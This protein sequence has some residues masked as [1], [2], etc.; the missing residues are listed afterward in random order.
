[1]IAINYEEYEA[2]CREVWEHNRRY[3]VEHQPSISDEQYD[4][5]MHR[6]EHIEA[7][8]PEWVG[9][10]SPTQRVGEAPTEGFK[11]FVHKVPM[12]SL[13]N[14]YTTNELEDFVN[15]IYKLIEKDSAEFT[16][17]IKMDGLAI[18][19]IY[20]DGIL[21]RGVT[22]GD[23]KQGDDVTTNIRTIRSIPLKLYGSKVPKYLEVRGEVFLP[24]QTFEKL[25]AERKKRDEVLWANPRNAAA[26][27]LK[28]LDPKE[29]AK[30]HLQA[31][32]YSVAEESSHLL[33]SQFDSH[34]FMHSLGL[35]TLPYLSKCQNLEEIIAF[36]TKV[37]SLRSSLPFDIDGVVVKLDNLLEQKRLGFTG[38]NPRWAVAY[39]FA[40]EQAVTR[41]IDIIV[42][43]GRTGVIT[44]TAYLEPVFL[45]GST[46]SKA[47]L[48]NEEEV[49]RKDVR[50]GDM[51][52]IEKG[53][54]VIPKVV[55]VNEEFRPAHSVPWQMPENCPSC[56]SKLVRTPGEVAVRCVN[57]Y[58][59]QE[60]QLRALSYFAGKEAMDIENMGEKI[61]EQ[62]VQRGFVAKPSDIYTLTLDQILQLEGFK[63]KSATK[64]IQSIEKSKQVDLPAFIMALSI[65]HIGTGTAELLARKF[66]SIEALSQASFED[67]IHID[68]IGDKVGNAICEYFSN[69]DNKM[70]INR[71]LALGVTPKPMNVQ[72]FKGHIFQNKNIVLT[73]TLLKYTRQGASSLIKE[74]GG[75]VTDSVSKKT[76]FVVAGESAGSK[77]EKAQSLGIKILDETAFE[78]LL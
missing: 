15:R 22:R 34:Q 47:T 51:V 42:S 49:Q 17:E 53:G 45:A 40:P 23:G 26:G 70:E 1:M 71:L 3:Y 57:V 2:L 46:I 77:L 11:T 44:P 68:G 10:S 50:V 18:S 16:V 13:A 31:Y 5:L 9:P 4:A 78:A 76:D 27:S 75:K 14:T 74:R 39:K 29:V 43:V 59:C 55:K 66:G 25:N 52:T 38:K 58:K 8:H 64:L 7:I 73:G 19:V 61:L 54:D 20:E 37:K 62:L 30:R 67:L 48:H 24:R 65:K 60:Q 69:E 12:L 35:P 33:T 21:T 56:G 36:A 72:S 32:F 63:I 28:M 6:I 41:V